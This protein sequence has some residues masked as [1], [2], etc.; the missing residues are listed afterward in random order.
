MSERTHTDHRV[1]FEAVVLRQCLD[2]IEQAYGHLIHNIRP[3]EKHADRHTDGFEMVS[4]LNT[5]PDPLLSSSVN[6]VNIERT[7]ERE[8]RRR[9]ATNRP[10]HGVAGAASQPVTIEEDSAPLIRFSSAQSS[11][12]KTKTRDSDRRRATETSAPITRDRSVSIHRTLMDSGRGTSVAELPTT[13]D[14]HYT[15][16]QPSDSLDHENQHS[17]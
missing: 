11:I 5:M 3:V 17:E 10:M 12:S 13:I 1:V 9:L 4:D 14:S 2:E 8:T 16:Y 6:S 15:S 7:Y